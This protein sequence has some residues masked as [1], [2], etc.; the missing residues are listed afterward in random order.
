[1]WGRKD[2]DFIK[3]LRGIRMLTE[4]EFNIFMNELKKDEK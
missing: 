1:M 3:R 2:P 4:A